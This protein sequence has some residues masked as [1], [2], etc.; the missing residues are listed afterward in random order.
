MARFSPG[1]AGKQAESAERGLL[2][3]TWD[4]AKA[5]ALGTHTTDRPDP[6]DF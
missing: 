6:L 3:G 2:Q 4:P 1:P 5:D